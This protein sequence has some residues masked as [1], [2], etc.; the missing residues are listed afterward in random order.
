[1]VGEVGLSSLVG[2]V[3]VDS[4]SKGG[5]RA[6]EALV[7]KE[8]VQL[9]R[10]SHA[11]VTRL[12]T[13]NSKD[14]HVLAAEMLAK[15]TLTG[16]EIQELLGMRKKASAR[17][18]S[19]SPRGKRGEGDAERERG[20]GAKSGGDAAEGAGK[21][22]DKEGDADIVIPELIL[23]PSEKSGERTAVA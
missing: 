5:R 11:R 19:A 20:E 8:V 15:E 12:L 21:G 23:E 2:P 17:G 16:G 1:M 7:D 4:M 9:L 14:L 22:D 18:E 3:H 10:D 6:T 13:R